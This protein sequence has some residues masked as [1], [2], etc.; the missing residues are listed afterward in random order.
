MREKI[1]GPETRSGPGK[2]EKKPLRLGKSS[3]PLG[4]VPKEGRE[5]G[6]GGLSTT[7]EEKKHRK[8]EYWGKKNFG[9]C[10]QRSYGRGG[11]TNPKE[12]DRKM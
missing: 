9:N 11:E 6:E 3:K 2:G 1:S 4:E 10:A 5:T 7:K 8:K 12:A